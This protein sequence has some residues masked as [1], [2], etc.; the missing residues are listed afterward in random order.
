M[1]WDEANRLEVDQRSESKP[2]QNVTRGLEPALLE[3]SLS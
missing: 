1:A 2:F 3:A